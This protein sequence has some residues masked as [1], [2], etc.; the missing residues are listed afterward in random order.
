MF[1]LKGASSCGVHNMY[2]QYVQYI[3]T[4]SGLS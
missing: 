3:D 2:E 4:V 1:H